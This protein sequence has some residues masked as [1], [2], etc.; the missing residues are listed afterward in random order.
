V[1]ARVGGRAD[2]VFSPGLTGSPTA[3]TGARATRPRG[4]ER[5]DAASPER[6]RRSP[7]ARSKPRAAPDAVLFVA[8]L[9]HQRAPTTRARPPRPLAAAHQDALIARV[10][11]QNPRTAVVLIAGSPVDMTSWLAKTPAFVQAWYGGSEGGDA[12]ASVPF[13]DVS[14]VGASCL[15]VPPIAEG[16]PRPRA[17]RARQFPGEGGKVYYDEGILVGYRWN[18]TKAIEPLFPFGHVS[19]TPLSLRAAAGGADGWPRRP[20]RATALAAA[21]QRR[22]ARG[23]RGRA[24]VRA[25]HQG[26]RCCGP[27]RS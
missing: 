14:P 13:G 27:S 17:G 16:L 5:A 12:L 3:A 4:H 24:G 15:H 8:G 21:Q 9:T 6:P 1:L 10:V 2:V 23:R 25:P 26:L 19:V 20:P 22:R 11:E 7:T 18:D